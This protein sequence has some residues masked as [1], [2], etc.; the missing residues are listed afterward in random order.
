MKNKLEVVG[1]VLDPFYET[2][3]VGFDE[4]GKIKDWKMY[5]C[6]S[7]VAAII[8]KFTPGYQFY[9]NVRASIQRFLSFLKFPLMPALGRRHHR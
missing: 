7:P 1:I 6:L 9:V 2:V 5:R 3:A 4:Q 8:Q